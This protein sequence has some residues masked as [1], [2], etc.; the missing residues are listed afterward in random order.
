MRTVNPLG[1]TLVE[2]GTPGAIF[3]IVCRIGTIII[4]HYAVFYAAY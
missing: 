2:K 4:M 3:R 1:S